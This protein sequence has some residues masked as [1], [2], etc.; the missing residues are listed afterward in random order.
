MLNNMVEVSKVNPDMTDE[1]MYKTCVQF[2]SDGY[3]SASQVDNEKTKKK[4]DFREGKPPIKQLLSSITDGK[5][6]NPNREGLL[7]VA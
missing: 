6:L 3:E 4:N 2:F 5:D 7:D 1:I